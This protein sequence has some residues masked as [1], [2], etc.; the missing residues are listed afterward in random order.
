MRNDAFATGPPRR[1]RWWLWLVLAAGAVVGLAVGGIWYDDHSA[2]RAWADACAEA[3]RLDPGWRWEELLAARP[4]PPDDRNVASRV[5]AMSAAMPPKWP[6]WSQLLTDAD[7]PPAPPPPM[8][9]PTS[10]PEADSPPTDEQRRHQFGEDVLM[11]IGGQQP[12]VRFRPD[13]VAALRKAMAAAATALDK[14]PG[15]EDLAPGRLPAAYARPLIN[16]LFGPDI[17]DT[18]AVA[19][20]LLVRSALLADDGQVDAALDDGRRILSVSRAAAA[21]PMFINM[22]VAISIRA[23]AVKQTERVLALG[24]PG[25]E[26]LDRT[27]R[28]YEAVLAEPLM[29]DALRGERAFV[30]D[31]V[32]SMDEGLLTAEKAF[33][34]APPPKVTGLGPVDQLLNRLRGGRGSKH[35]SAAVLRFHTFLIELSKESPDALRT[36]ADHIAAYRAGMDPKVQ[37]ATQT[38]DMIF[39][40][41]RRSRALVAAAV[42][43]LAAEQFR[44]ER[45]QWPESLD[46]LVKA[47]VVSAVPADPFDGQPLRMRHLADGLVIYSVGADGVDDG[48]LIKDDLNAGIIAKDIGVR[49][50]DPAH[51]RQTPK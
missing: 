29:P 12:A 41:D 1:R 21:Q 31:C 23:M 43:A 40:G 9:D 10:P 39:V 4:N 15:L 37:K 18:R 17:Q 20:L 24:E 50:W 34:D 42:A 46:E 27:R 11:V 3:D 14:A 5:H 13:Q 22:L 8:P 32:R 51:R 25:S 7:L 28:A 16:N 30:E 19:R 33:D 47:M 2:G 36:R 45:A 26:A 6:D 48:G 49:L 35:H 38:I 44:R